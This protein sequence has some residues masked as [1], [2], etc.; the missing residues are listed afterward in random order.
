MQA[1]RDWDDSAANEQ[2]AQ[3]TEVGQMKDRQRGEAQAADKALQDA[4][5]QY[6]ADSEEAQEARQ[7]KNDT[8]T[9][10]KKERKSIGGKDDRGRGAEG[11]GMTSQGD[12][13]SGSNATW[14]G[15]F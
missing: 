7:A 4:I 15:G 3:D 13:S 1:S 8:L 12:L 14:Y 10:H 2:E 6:G 11:D 9:R 5:D